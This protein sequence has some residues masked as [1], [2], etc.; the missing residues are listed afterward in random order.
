MKLLLDS[1]ALVWFLDGDAT[2]SAAASAL[3][4]R[5]DSQSLVSAVTAW[6]IAVKTGLGKLRVPYSVGEEFEKTLKESGF[7]LL[8]LSSS[9]LER[10][11]R[12]P[13]HHRDPFDRL[14]AAEALEQSATLISHN[15]I[16]DA[17]GVKRVW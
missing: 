11:A 8:P 14:L 9:A 10:T 16:F 2:M 6:E 12:L 4:E 17:Y 7:E 5:A 3:I 15:E 1:P 13:D